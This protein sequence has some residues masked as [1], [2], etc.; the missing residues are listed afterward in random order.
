MDIRTAPGSARFGRERR[1]RRQVG[2]AV[3]AVA[4]LGLGGWRR[5][6]AHDAEE[7]AEETIAAVNTTLATGDEAALDELFAP[8]L[9]VHPPHRSLATGEEFGHNLAGLKAAFAE[10]RRYFPDGAFTVEDSVADDDKVAGRFTFRGTPDAAA[11]GL[12]VAPSTPLEAEGVIFMVVA[13]DRVQ[14]FWAYFD[15]EALTA[16]ARLATPR[17]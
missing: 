15:P 8:D 12:P 9:A 6:A 7:V 11:F 10:M 4:V 17:P 13:D 1:S 5:A 3:A 2:G 16:V 14:E